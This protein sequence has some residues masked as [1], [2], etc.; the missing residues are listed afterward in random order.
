MMVFSYQDVHNLACDKF[1][2]GAYQSELSYPGQIVSESKKARVFMKWILYHNRLTSANWS[3]I[4]ESQPWQ[5]EVLLNR[6]KAK[7][8]PA[9]N[10][11]GP[12]N[13]E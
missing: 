11:S 12:V 10:E 9:E 6:M 8:D 1:F 4:G 2:S 5:I 3:D 13:L 7:K